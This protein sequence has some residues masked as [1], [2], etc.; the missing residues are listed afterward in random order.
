[1]N[2]H[3]EDLVGHFHGLVVVAHLVLLDQLAK[4][5]GVLCHG[6]PEPDALPPAVPER[7]EGKG[8]VLLAECFT[9]DPS[10]REELVPAGVESLVHRFLGYQ[11]HGIFRHLRFKR[12]K[13]GSSLQVSNILSGPG[14]TCVVYVLLKPDLIS[15]DDQVLGNGPLEA[16]HA[17]MEARGLFDAGGDVAKLLEQ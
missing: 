5:D 11:D 12:I 13:S 10:L 4:Q 9:S 16:G 17:G 3:I 14:P 8:R 1:M 15:S 6:N 7:Q 2:R